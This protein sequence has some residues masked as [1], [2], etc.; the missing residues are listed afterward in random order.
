MTTC[1]APTTTSCTFSG[2]CTPSRPE[3]ADSSCRVP[4]RR[5][6]SGLPTSRRGS[7]RHPTT[8]SGHESHTRPGRFPQPRPSLSSWLRYS[9]NTRQ[10]RAARFS[11]RPGIYMSVALTCSRRSGPVEKSLQT[12]IDLSTEEEGEER[13][14]VWS[15]P[16]ASTPS[17]ELFR[18]PA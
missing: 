9:W 6:R 7:Y 2:P 11:T 10:R 3:R 15:Y 18:C 16:R 13:G 4:R 17:T 14:A 8:R 1:P 5:I 12:G